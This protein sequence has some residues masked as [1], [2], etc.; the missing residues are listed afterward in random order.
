MVTARATGL[1][2]RVQRV[3]TA[4]ASHGQGVGTRG[5]LQCISMAHQQGRSQ[6]RHIDHEQGALAVSTLGGFWRV[7]PSAALQALQHTPLLGQSAAI[8][9]QHLAQQAPFGQQQSEG[10]QLPVALSAF[11]CGG[12]AEPGLVAHGGERI[13]ASHT[14][15]SAWQ[16]CTRRRLQ[17]HRTQQLNPAQAGE[18]DRLEGIKPHQV[19]ARAQVYLDR[20]GIVPLQRQMAQG[21]LAR[22][23]WSGRGDGGAHGGACNPR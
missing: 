8:G 13:A 10:L 16:C 17:H 1:G 21:L 15:H 2:C 11:Q 20:F 6:P 12:V 4:P 14:G 22:R 7:A 5:K 23:A 19:A 18:P 3:A 9:R